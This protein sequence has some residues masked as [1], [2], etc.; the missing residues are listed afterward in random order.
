L[1]ALHKYLRNN[2]EA[3]RVVKSAVEVL[4]KK[5]TE[6]PVEVPSV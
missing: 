3:Y 1:A 6:T 5:E 4:V 2:E